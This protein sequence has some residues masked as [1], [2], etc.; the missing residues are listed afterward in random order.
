MKSALVVDDHPVTHIG[1]GQLLREA[2]YDPV[3]KALTD[4]EALTAA[5]AHDPDLIVLD[6]GMPGLG[7]LNLLE[8]LLR[9]A[10]N[11]RIL[12][13]SMNEQ[14]AFVSKALAGGAA[15]YLTKNSGPDDFLAAVS[16]LEQGEIYLSHATALA[17]AT[18]QTGG[19]ADPLSSLTSREHQVLVLIGK[20][21]DLQGIA[22]DLRISYKTAANA[23]SSLKKKLGV[24][25]TPELIRYAI[26]VGA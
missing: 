14:T 5:E 13:F 1:C 26:S 23:S 18:T 22:D 17:V 6:L 19:R 15:G 20:G 2:G 12:I 8:P 3:L 11:A 21:K 9:R 16:A 4:K 7:G 25:T 10:P 24:R